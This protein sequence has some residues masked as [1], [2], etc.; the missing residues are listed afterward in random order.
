M[1]T[2]FAIILSL[3][4]LILR[5]LEVALELHLLFYIHDLILYISSTIIFLYIFIA[6]RRVLIN[7]F[8]SGKNKLLRVLYIIIALSLTTLFIILAIDISINIF[9]YLLSVNIKTVDLDMIKNIYGDNFNITKYLVNLLPVYFIYL[10]KYIE[11]T[12]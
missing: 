3:F 10:S 4:L 11:K 5:Y 6:K 1:K 8:K 2:N 12:T 9:N 7:I